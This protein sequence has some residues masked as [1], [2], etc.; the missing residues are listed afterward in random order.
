MVWR[1][2]WRERYGK[3]VSKEKCHEEEGRGER[4]EREDEASLLAPT[5]A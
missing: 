4:S 5:P 1:D 3:L 2:R